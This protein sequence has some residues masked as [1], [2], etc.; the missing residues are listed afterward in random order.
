MAVA[1]TIHVSME[2]PAMKSVSPRAFGTTV[3]VQHRLLENTARFSSE[4]VARTTKQLESTRL[5][6]T[7]LLTTGIKPSKYSVILIQ[8][9]GSRGI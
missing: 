1:G 5:D 6:C 3:R 4:E 9:P 8:S 2:E 7:K